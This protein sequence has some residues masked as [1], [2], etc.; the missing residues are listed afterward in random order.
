MSFTEQQ[1]YDALGVGAKKPEA[2]EPAKAAQEPTE[3]GAREPETAE[4]AEEGTEAQEPTGAKAEPEGSAQAGQ[5]TEEQRREA[6]AKLLPYQK[7]DFKGMYKALE[8]KKTFIESVKDHKCAEEI[9]A[10]CIAKYQ[11]EFPQ[12]SKK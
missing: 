3:E 6:L 5:Q 12:Y 10:S 2:A 7:A 4:P 8:G 1:L 11:Q 9:I